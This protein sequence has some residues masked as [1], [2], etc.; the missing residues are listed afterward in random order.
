MDWM[1]GAVVSPGY[2]GYE[3]VKTRILTA[4]GLRR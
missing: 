2:L 3:E 1:K 4:G